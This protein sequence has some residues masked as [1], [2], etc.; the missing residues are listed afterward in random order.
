MLHRVCAPDV[1]RFKL[2]LLA[3]LCAVFVALTS[4]VWAGCFNFRNNAVGGISINT[5]G[6]VAGPIDAD[7]KFLLKELKTDVAKA[8][9][10]MHRPVGMRMLSLRGLEAAIDDARRNN[11]GELPDEVKFLAGLQRIQYV[12]LYPEQNDIVI[13]GPGEGWRVDEQAYVVGVTTGRPVLLLD[14]LLVAFRCTTNAATG[15]GISC[16]IDPTAEGRQNLDTLLKRVKKFSDTVPAAIEKALGPQQISITGVPPESHFARV[17]VAAD[18]K[19]KRYAMGLED[20]P[21]KGMPSFIDLMAKKRSRPDNMMPRWWLACNYAPLARSEDGLAWELRGAGVKAMTEDDLVAADGTVKAT[22]RANPLAQ[23]WADTLTE[24]YDELSGQDAVFGELRNLMDLCVVAALIEKH[25]LLGKVD[26][27]LPLITDA[28][29]ELTIEQWLAPKTVAS[30]CSAL[31]AGSDWIIT[32]SGGVQV[33]SWEVAQRTEMN[34]D[35]EQIR[36]KAKSA[37]NKNWWWN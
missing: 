17:M 30:Q 6:V 2:I 19:M 3:T 5:A 21:I 13:A 9:A 8:P 36:T 37:D 35:V 16:S 26:L 1:R 12:F 15:R 10:D 32:A 25:G 4:V 11:L 24:K 27:A 14:D 34:A 22:G 33:E 7:L 18:Y 20:A 28:S 29:S 23:Q 31:K